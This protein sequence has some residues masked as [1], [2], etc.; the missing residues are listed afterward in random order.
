MISPVLSIS[1]P[2]GCIYIHSNDR[3]IGIQKNTEKLLQTHEVSSQG[4][5]VREEQACHQLFR[6]TVGDGG[7]TYEWYKGQVKERVGGTCMW[8]LKHDHYQEWLN[9]ASGPLLVTADPGCGK[10]VLAKYLIDHAL[11]RSATI[12]YFFFK[13]QDQN[14]VRQALCALLHQLFSQEPYLIKHAMKQYSKNG[15]KLIH[16]TASLWRILHDAT[17]DAQAGPVIIVLDA[18]DEC[19]ESEFPSLIWNVE[20][21]F[22][23]GERPGDKVKYLLTCRPYEQIVSKFHG[24]LRNF[25]YIRIPGE[26]ESETISQEVNCVIDSRLD[27]LSEEKGYSPEIM[28]YLRKR[29]RECSHRTYLWVYL[30]FDYLEN[31]SFKKTQKGVE[32]TIAKLPQSVNEAY[33]QILA[34]SKKDPMVRKA[35]SIVLAASRPLTVS[36]MNIAVNVNEE[37]RSIHGLDLEQQKDF[38][39]RLRT[40]CGLFISIHH[41]KIY[42]LHQTAREFLINLSS[43]V[44]AAGCDLNS[45]W[46]HSI[47]NKQAHLVLAEICVLYL[48]LFN[49]DE[50]ENCEGCS[51]YADT[52]DDQNSQNGHVNNGRNWLNVLRNTDP[53]PSTDSH[54]FLN[55]SASSW[56]FHFYEADVDDCNTIVHTTLRICDP[57]LKSFSKWYIYVG[58][59]PPPTALTLASSYG[60]RSV[61]KLIL[62]KGVEV[63]VRDGGLGRTP[64]ACAVRGGHETVVKL[65]L[66]HKGV[67]PNLVDYS[68]RSPLYIAIENGNEAIAKL[69][70]VDDRIDVNAKFNPDG[71]THPYGRSTLQ[72]LAKEQSRE[73]F[74]KARIKLNVNTQGHSERGDFETGYKGVKYIN[75]QEKSERGDCE[76]GYK[77]ITGSNTIERHHTSLLYGQLCRARVD[78]YNNDVNSSDDNRY[79]SGTPL[80]VAIVLGHTTIVKCLL[81]RDN[82][83]ISS[84]GSTVNY[85]ATPLFVAA[86]RGDEEVVKGLLTKTRMNINENGWAAGEDHEQVYCFHK[87]VYLGTP[88]S[89]AAWRGHKTIVELLLGRGK[90]DVN[91]ICFIGQQP[92]IKHKPGYLENA[93]YR[94]PIFRDTPSQGTPLFCAAAKG[95][96][97]IVRLLL[98]QQTIRLNLEGCIVDE[99]GKHWLSEEMVRQSYKGTPLSIAA[100]KGH[101]TIVKLLLAQDGVDVNAR[102]YVEYESK[103]TYQDACISEIYSHAT[104]LGLAAAEEHEDISMLLL[105]TERIEIDAKD[106]H[107][108]TPLWWATLRGNKAIVELLLKHG[109]NV[110]AE[111]N[112]GD[113][114]L[115]YATQEGYDEIVELLLRYKVDVKIESGRSRNEGTLSSGWLTRLSKAIF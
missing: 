66:T 74:A 69:L 35:L 75:T 90:V 12:C 63:N 67:D 109:A 53:L 54:G 110:Q 56:L 3:R 115:S 33:E 47:T 5:K 88:L 62:S 78:D 82:V 44:A 80:F 15:E 41:N 111:D 64:L 68:K 81:N 11:P 76:T 46:H 25:P 73:M 61:V 112:S 85:Y 4:E 1:I 51:Y 43:P 72:F 20:E 45:T 106:Q 70:L 59:I 95:Y 96:E 93:T 58:P 31:E 2:F 105:A 104:P 52:E 79:W 16:S 84:R 83:D 19:A 97:E 87:V 30:V 40:W 50:A 36:E 24:L 49:N 7:A 37:S 21:R 38:E 102:T 114:P 94:A 14:T 42:F 57:A 34:K 100:W 98:D 113:T 107:G 99:H 77:G 108:R 65:L 101:K 55:Y 103:T 17:K 32:R 48:D 60:L 18:L 9:R 28:S 92:F 8:L 71:P 86:A 23:V 22:C 27:Q 91:A 26:Q 89:V 10:S 13:D 6:L 29:M 39:T